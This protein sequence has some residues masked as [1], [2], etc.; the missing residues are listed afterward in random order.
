MDKIYVDIRS[1]GSDIKSH[2]E[3]EDIV[4]IEELLGLIEDLSYEKNML[5]EEY[6]NFKTIVKYNYRQ[7]RDE[8]L[9]L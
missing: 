2:F 5:E 3:N 1:C 4:S 9:Y 6:E 8:E 7:L